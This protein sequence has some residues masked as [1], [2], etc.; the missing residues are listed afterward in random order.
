MG[1]KKFVINKNITANSCRIQTYGSPMCRY[2]CIWFIDFMSKGKTSL[3][4]TNLFPPDEYKKTI[5]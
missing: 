1:H 3:D 2:C 5:K 4:Y